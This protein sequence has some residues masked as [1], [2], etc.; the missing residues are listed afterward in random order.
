LWLSPVTVYLNHTN[1]QHRSSA[2]R[3]LHFGCT[4]FEETGKWPS[5]LH[6]KWP[7]VLHG[8]WPTAL[9]G[10]WPTALHGKWPSA[11]HGKWP[12][13]LHGKWPSAL[14]GKLSQNRRKNTEIVGI[15]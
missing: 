9:H 4:D 11:L 8:K 5:A 10:K 7:T 13:A 3:N 12:T 14:H 2:L 15:N 1:W 6:G